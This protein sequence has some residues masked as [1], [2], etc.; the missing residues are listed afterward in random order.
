M[1]K[2]LGFVRDYFTFLTVIAF[3]V[4]L[5]TVVLAQTEPVG[6]DTITIAGSGRHTNNTFPTLVQAQAGNVTA[7][8]ISSVRATQAWQGYYGNITGTIALD[9]ANNNTLYDWSLPN[10]SRFVVLMVH[11]K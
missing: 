9:D 4:I 5:S 1:K 7:L 3:I 10:P 11:L 8:V 6:P 2:R